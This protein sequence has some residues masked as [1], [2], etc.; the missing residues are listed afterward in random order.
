MDPFL[1]HPGIFPDLHH[2]LATYVQSALQPQLPEPYY[3]ATNARIWVEITERYRDPDVHVLRPETELN[4]GQE[5]NG[6]NGGIA[7]AT[8]TRTQ[9]V[10]IHVPQVRHDDMREAFVEI[11][12]RRDEEE[13]L[14]T[15]I[16]ILSPSNKTLGA[17]GGDLYR[18]KQR[19]LLVSK[20]HLVEIDLLRGGRHT[21]AVPL[22]RALEKA[23]PFDYHVCVHQF[24][25]WEDYFV[26]PIQLRDRLPE[27]AVPLLP[28][29]G[30]VALD[31]QVA[32]DLA[33][34]P[35]PYRRR[36]KYRER[37]PVPPLT[38]EQAQWVAQVLRQK[39]VVTAQQ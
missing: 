9:P 13:R 1:E 38:S 15:T 28:G 8:T 12:V 39:G 18:T 14:V 30:F 26:Y 22:E 5:V 36:V 21:T 17:E 4:G 24:D 32:F 37:T 6:G 33:Y 29:D 2:G 19:D 35:G 11:F 23:G 31:L 20:T 7:V 34:D 27:I 3:A 25:R 16:E 10:L